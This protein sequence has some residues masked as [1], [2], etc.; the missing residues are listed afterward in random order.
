MPGSEYALQ[1]PDLGQIGPIR[2]S[3]WLVEEGEHVEAGDRVAEL[4]A[5]PATYDLPS[6]VAGYL[7]RCLVDEDQEVHA[8]QLIGLIQGEDNEA[9]LP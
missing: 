5:G 6:P 2:L 8:G 4:L 3:L 1:V 7:A 9:P